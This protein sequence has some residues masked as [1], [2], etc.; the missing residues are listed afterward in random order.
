[1]HS[2]SQNKLTLVGRAGFTLV[3]VLISL[4]ILVLIGFTTSKAVVDAANLKEILKG[5]TEFANEFRTSMSFIERDLSQIFNPRWFLPPE[6]VALDPYAQPAAPTNPNTA[7]GAGSGG[8]VGQ[9]PPKLSIDQLNRF[10]RGQAFQSFEFWGPVFDT[11]GIRPSRFQGKEAVMSF[12]TASH[13]RI[14]AQK[15]ESIYSKVR[16]ELVKQPPNPNLTKVEN[17]KLAG[18]YQLIKTEYTRAFDLEESR[19][20]KFQTTY[21]VLNNIKTLKFGYLKPET[22]EPL[23]D[24][25]SANVDTAGR[26]PEAVEIEVSVQAA[27]DRV[28]DAK[29]LF[30][31]EAPNDVLPTTY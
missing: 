25:D 28:Q 27:N 9:A 16:Y 13:F 20:G 1:M 7:G 24:W 29:L 4:F 15:K 26:F 3:E 11:T 30:K 17:E 2:N 22:K 6:Q 10:L 19:D 8:N 14:Y 5:E 31:L 23:R 21:V 12:V 18:L